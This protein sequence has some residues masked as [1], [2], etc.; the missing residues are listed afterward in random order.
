MRGF[1]CVVKPKIKDE[2]CVFSLRVVSLPPGT[3]LQECL[4]T[5][6]ENTSNPA[7]WAH[8]RDTL[9]SR[10]TLHLCS[11]P[12]FFHIHTH[13]PKICGLYHGVQYVTPL[14]GL[15]ELAY[16]HNLNIQQ[17]RLCSPKACIACIILQLLKFIQ[18]Q[19]EKKKKSKQIDVVHF[20]CSDARTRWKNPVACYEWTKSN[21]N[22]GG[23]CN[24][25]LILRIRAM[26]CSSLSQQL[27]WV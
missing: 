11:S 3:A 12:I 19:R 13:F 1:L 20:L 27:L 2:F 14:F 24:F 9:C 15:K 23:P 17:E 18:K 16:K 26:D 4:S 6:L 22:V 5:P 7:Q 8:L 21:L 10:W 25:S